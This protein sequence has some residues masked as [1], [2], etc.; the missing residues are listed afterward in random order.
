MFK[1]R[2]LFDFEGALREL[3]SMR[4]A[5]QRCVEIGKLRITQESRNASE[6]ERMFGKSAIDLPDQP[7]CMLIMES[8]LHRRGREMGSFIEQLQVDIVGAGLSLISQHETL[9]ATSTRD[10]KQ[11]SKQLGLVYKKHDDALSRYNT[12]R[13]RMIQYTVDVVSLS[14]DSL[15]RLDLYHCAS[16]ACIDYESATTEYANSVS[17]AN[18]FRDS[19]Y[20]EQ[21]GT[22]LNMLDEVNLLWRD[23]IHESCMKLFLFEVAFNRNLQYENERTF[24]DLEGVPR[25]GNERGMTDPPPVITPL[26]V[27]TP[28]LTIPAPSISD[29]STRKTLVDSIWG[30][31]NVD[32]QFFQVLFR[33]GSQS[34]LHF[35][36]IL[37]EQPAGLPSVDALVRIGRILIILLDECLLDDDSDTARRVCA[38][39]SVFFAI[40]DDARKKYIQSQIYHHDIWNRV[41][42]WEDALRMTIAEDLISRSIGEQFVACMSLDGFGSYMLMFGVTSSSALDIC[43]KVVDDPVTMRRLAESISLAKERQDKNVASLK[44]NS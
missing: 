29:E 6:F 23:F 42:F 26:S 11:L 16:E 12:T 41:T 1:D 10:G 33:R 44:A 18:E 13:V 30:D 34:R 25:G 7:E 8:A 39:G 28:T 40:T 4:S 19:Q 20:V 24:K 21:M 9:I 35:V 2:F 22:I 14:S 32:E 27:V 17:Y 43:G 5:V 36:T 37:K 15:D 31:D 3:Q 38:L